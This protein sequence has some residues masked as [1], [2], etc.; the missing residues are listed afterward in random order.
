MTIHL[1]AVTP[2]PATLDPQARTIEAIVSTGAET[3]RPGYIE[4]LDLRGADL[5][6]LIGGPVLDAHRASSTRDQLGV[7]DAAEVRREGLWVRIRF[8]SNEAAQAVLADIG[9]GTL[10]GL[11]IGYS[12]AEWKEARDG[13][14]RIRTATRWTPLEVSIVPV[15]ADPG[16]HFR[17]GGNQMD[18]QEQTAERPAE[19]ARQTRAQANAEIR[20][21]AETAGLSRAWADEQIDADAT[22]EDAR[23]AAFEAM[24]TRSVQATTRTTRAEIA[25]D[26]TDPTVTAARAGEALYARAHPGHTLSDAARPFAYMTT[27]DLA[28]DCLRRVGVSMTGAATETLITRALHTTSDFPLILGDAV[29][30]ELRRAY[31]AAPSGIR[32][33]ARQGTIRDFRP[34]RSIMFDEAPELEKVLEGGEFQHGTMDESAELY[35]LET[36]GKIFGI[37]R[38]ALVNDDLG[39][40]TTIPG[41]LGTAAS[42]FEAMQLAAKIAA[43][44]LMSDGVAVFAAAGHDN[45][46]AATSTGEGVT[47]LDAIKADLSAARLA[48]RKQT[49][50]SGMLIDVTPRFV[51]VPPD[52]E[53]TMEQALSEVQATNTD[54][55]NPFSALSLV[56]EPRLTSDSQWYVVADPDLIDGLE[57]SYLEGAPGPQI[58]TKVG[59][60]VDG[61]Q[62]KVRLDFGCGWLD[63]RGWFRVG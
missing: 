58:E 28:R 61:V 4:R 11:S 19:T 45:Q 6:R 8:R 3:A 38:Q 40:F 29:G 36:F 21:I 18:T 12:V 51:L 17:H 30:R 54:E 9:D 7:I 25:F 31:Q 59:F 20:T 24:R 2:H 49:G 50:L 52:L 41:R 5:S 34:K 23:A 35:S 57:Y 26:H 46:K 56:V 48:M 13:D 22:P 62:M 43:N 63:H 39:A 32:Q 44:P 42:A 15:P 16:A 47:V 55:T 1:R 14:R 10:R 60:E 27:V 33:L 37:S 53:T